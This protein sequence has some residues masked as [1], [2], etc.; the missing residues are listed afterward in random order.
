MNISVSPKIR[1][2]SRRRSHL[3]VGLCALSIAMLGATCAASASA[4]SSPTADHATLPGRP[5]TDPVQ[6]KATDTGAQEAKSSRP[7]ATDRKDPRAKLIA[8]T[9][10]ML[11]L[12][13]ELQTEIARSDQNTLSL[14]LV[15]KAEELQKLAATVKAE[16]DKTP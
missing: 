16:M 14:A 10:K 2:L 6:A 12:S 13:R 8:D 1:A 3:C 11:R 4:Q 15:K 5:G 9:Q 7:P